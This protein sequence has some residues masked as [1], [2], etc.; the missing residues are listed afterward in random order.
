MPD[1]TTQSEPPGWL[2]NGHQRTPPA[3]PSPLPAATDFVDK[4]VVIDMIAR[5]ISPK[6]ETLRDTKDKVGKRLQTALNK[7]R[8]QASADGRVCLGHAVLW[9]RSKWPSEPM[10]GM[11]PTTPQHGEGLATAAVGSWAIADVV[12][13]GALAKCQAALRDAQ[14]RVRQLE[15]ENRELSR[16]LAIAEPL[17]QKYQTWVAGVTVS[18]GRPKPRR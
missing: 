17:A 1:E 5:A 11:L 2:P 6:Y 16:K 8:L 15:S 9:A 10:L 18:G 12:P 3:A 4:R 14:D 7:G 13:G